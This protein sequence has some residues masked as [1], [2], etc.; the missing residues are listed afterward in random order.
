MA[1]VAND[2]SAATVAGQP[3]TVAILANDTLDGA[4]VQ[5]ADLTGA[6]EILSQPAAGEVIVNPDG[7]I[8]YT[9]E[10]GFTGAVEFTYRIDTGSCTIA[11]TIS[12]L[13]GTDLSL[14]FL[15]PWWDEVPDGEYLSVE[16]AVSPTWSLTI[17]KDGAAAV[18]DSSFGPVPEGETLT[19]SINDTLRSLSYCCHFNYLAS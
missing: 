7:T 14:D 9:P 15:P 3:V 10:D 8:T 18:V 17:I 5:L 16:P 1:L 13:P 11:E 4:P 19:A 2:D 6:P 12:L